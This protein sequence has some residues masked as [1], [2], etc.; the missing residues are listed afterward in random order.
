MFGVGFRAYF[1]TLPIASI[2]CNFLA[3][4]GKR[5]LFFGFLAF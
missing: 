1:W 3:K 5:L 2:G 4:I